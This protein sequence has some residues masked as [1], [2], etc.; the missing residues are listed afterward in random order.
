MSELTGDH[1]LSKEQIA[2]TQVIVCTPESGISSPE[3][4]EREPTHNLSALLL[5]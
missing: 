4:V 3:R 1:Q 5:L 2:G